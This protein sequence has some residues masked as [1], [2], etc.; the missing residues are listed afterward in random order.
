MNTPII[1]ACAF[2]AF[3]LA[4]AFFGI[5]AKGKPDGAHRLLTVASVEKEYLKHMQREGKCAVI[6]IGF[7]TNHLS[8]APAVTR[9]LRD[10]PLR[11][12]KCMTW[13][14]L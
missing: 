7:F 5:F 11:K 8:Q 3:L 1:L 6:C 4:L 9:C 12:K 10:F 2:V 14:G 13:R